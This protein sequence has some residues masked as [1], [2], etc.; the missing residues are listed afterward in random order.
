MVSSGPTHISN[1]IGVKQV[2]VTVC[3]LIWGLITR[4]A[5]MVEL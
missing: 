5:Q 2:P 1:N 4:C 3:F